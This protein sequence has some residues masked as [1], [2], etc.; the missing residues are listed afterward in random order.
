[1]PGGSFTIDAWLTGDRWQH[2]RIRDHFGVDSDLYVVL[3]EK[4]GKYQAYTPLHAV[5]EDMVKRITALE[6]HD[7]VRSSFTIDAEVG[8]RV[9]TIDATISGESGGTFTIDAVIVPYGSFTIDAQLV[10]RF[11][12]DA[13]IS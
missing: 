11:T 9:F 2:H 13:M 5:L 10:G 6:V 3:S 8:D 12:I 1:M 4:V 7:R